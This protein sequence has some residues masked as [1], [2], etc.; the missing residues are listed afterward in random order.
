VSEN[1]KRAGPE[2]RRVLLD[3]KVVIVTGAAS[4]IGRASATLFSQNG[5]K[6]IVADVDE[7]GGLETV[8]KSKPGSAIFVKTDVSRS[9]D[10]QNCVRAAV[11]KFGRLDGV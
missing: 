4:G 1:F 8:N 2:K 3:S 7:K 10:T 11:E 5:A 9:K 6:V